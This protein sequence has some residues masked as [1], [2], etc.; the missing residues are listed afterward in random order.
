MLGAMST[1]SRMRRTAGRAGRLGGWI[2]LGWLAAAP[3]C[4][5]QTAETTLVFLG[6]YTRDQSRGIYVTRLDPVTGRLTAPELAAE[7]RNPSFLALHPS[8][9]FLYAVSEL[10]GSGG[11]SAFALDPATGRLRG[12]NQQPSGGRG[13]CHVSVDHTGRMLLVANY[14]SGSVAALPIRDDGSL[15]PPVSVVQHVGASVHPRRQGG[16]HAHC[17]LPD[18]QNRRALVCDLGVDKVFAYP[19]DAAGGGLLTNGVAAATLPPGAGPRHLTFSANG[20]FVYVINE[21]NSTLAVFAY[22]SRRG[23][24]SLRQTV[25]TLP[26]DFTGEN[27]TA[28]IHVHPGGKFLY[29]S[30]RGH[31]SLAVFAINRATGRLSLIEH[32]PT[33][34]RTPR[35]FGLDPTGRWLLAA[36]QNSDS[37]VVF[38]VDDRTGRPTPTG[39]VLEVGAPVCVR[40]VPPSK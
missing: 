3:P 20:R 2:V 38:R 18:P 1:F 22:Q 8:R 17:I 15:A 30:N 7:A 19:L 26:A 27:T 10:D 25:G 6:T 21:L 32:V 16:P 14:S 4:P 39:Q 37:V 23:E 33:G 12:L 40:F 29:G 36:N 31:D 5:A 9:Q 34:G 35:N 11:V 13:P 28:D 24:F